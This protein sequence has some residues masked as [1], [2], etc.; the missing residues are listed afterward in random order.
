MGCWTAQLGEWGEEN[1]R[2]LWYP[3]QA[4]KRLDPDFL[5]RCA[6]EIR[7]CAFH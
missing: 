6:R 5:L 3:T 7:V 4:K 1:A 2:L